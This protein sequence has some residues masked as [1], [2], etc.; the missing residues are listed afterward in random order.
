MYDCDTPGEKWR[1]YQA[2]DESFE[3]IRCDV[4]EIIDEMGL[5]A[6]YKMKLLLGFEEIIEN[7]IS[8]AYDSS[9]LSRPLWLSIFKSENKVIMDIMDCGTPF[10]PLAMEDARPKE[11]E[12]QERKLG[13]YGIHLVK[14]FFTECSYS[15]DDYGEH[16]VNHLTLVMN[17]GGVDGS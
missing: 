8:Y 4:E 10:D 5:P 9:S 13:G 14:K 15:Y 2:D 17:I 1:R 12:L 11:T 7:I 3:S 6:E 16:K